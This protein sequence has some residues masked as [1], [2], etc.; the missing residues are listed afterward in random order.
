M[1]HWM[2]TEVGLGSQTRTFLHILPARRQVLKNRW[3]PCGEA[4]SRNNRTWEGLLK[5]RSL[6]ESPLQW[7]YPCRWSPY[8]GLLS[9]CPSCYLKGLYTPSGE[10]EKDNRV[11][12]ALLGWVTMS[13]SAQKNRLVK[14]SVKLKGEK[15]SGAGRSF[16]E[17]IGLG[18][19]G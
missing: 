2:K 16:K 18:F 17:H 10:G 3:R 19:L 7:L 5:T 4:G 12:A 15:A 1:L 8:E 14:G 9:R 11:E 6:S 13:V